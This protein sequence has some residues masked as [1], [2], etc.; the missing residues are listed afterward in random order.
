MQGGMQRFNIKFCKCI[1]SSIIICRIYYYSYLSRLKFNRIACC[2]AISVSGSEQMKSK[3][4]SVIWDQKFFLYKKGINGYP[5]YAT[6]TG[7]AYI[8]FDSDENWVVSI[9]LCA[10]DKFHIICISFKLTLPPR[11]YLIYSFYKF[12]EDINGTENNLMLYHD[13]C[14][15]DCPNR[16][17]NGWLYWDAETN[18]WLNDSSIDVSCHLTCINISIIY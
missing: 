17:T 14:D 10:Y 2:K 11:L 12:S 3:Y 13:T 9:I 1:F 15:E 6:A 5:I 7:N 4:P 18:Y 8:L 16:C